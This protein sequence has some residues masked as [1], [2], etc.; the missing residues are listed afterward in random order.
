MSNYKEKGKTR[1]FLKFVSEDRLDILE[2]GIIR[3][4]QPAAL[5]DPFEVNPIISEFDSDNLHF[6]NNGLVPIYEKM[7]QEDI[8]YTDLRLNSKKKF[9]DK[10]KDFANNFGILSLI[11]NDDMS[12]F[13]SVEVVELNDP[14]RNLLM[15]AHYAN[16]HKGFVIEFESNF[17][18][19]SHGVTYEKIIPIKYS[20]KRAVLLF[21]DVENKS[22]EPFYMKGNDWCYEN[23]W[24]VVLPLSSGD[25]ILKNDIYLFKFNQKSIISITC[26]CKMSDENKAKIKEIIKQPDF[27]SLN[28]YEAAMDNEHTTVIFNGY[29]GENYQWTNAQELGEESV[30]PV[31]Y[32]FSPETINSFK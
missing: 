27:G 15:W 29:D 14:R 11:S 20:D 16:E 13:P 12:S 32:Q 23:E 25:S 4:T 17:L 28:Y 5:N 7:S 9:R 22:M 2:K 19:E 10:Y 21:E 1:R 3:F 24:R 8:E 30:R 18:E 31:Y 26:G 6:W